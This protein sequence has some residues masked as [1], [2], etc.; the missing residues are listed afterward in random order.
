MRATWY[1]R[2]W[3]GRIARI[4]CRSQSVRG[5]SIIR[6]AAPETSSEPSVAIAI[7]SAPRARV[8][9]ILETSLSYTFEAVATQTTGLSSS[10]SAIGP[11][12]N[13]PSE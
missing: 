12:F 8:S 4:G 10:S 6:S 1:A 11:F 5:T 13:S 7:T 9:W 3:S 2:S